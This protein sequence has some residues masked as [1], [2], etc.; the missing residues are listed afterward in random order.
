MDQYTSDEIASDYDALNDPRQVMQE[1][2]GL[3]S[4]L[5]QA[6]HRLGDA[7]AA[8]GLT[9]REW[10]SEYARLALLSDQLPD[11]TVDELITRLAEFSAA[12]GPDWLHGGSAEVARFTD[13]V[14]ILYG[15]L[16]PLRVIAQRQRMLSASERSVHPL[17]RTLGSARVG[18]PLDLVAGALRDL[19]ALSP[20]LVPLTAEEWTEAAPASPHPE[21]RAEPHPENSEYSGAANTSFDQSLLSGPPAAPAQPFTRLRDFAPTPVTSTQHGSRGDPGTWLRTRVM[22]LPMYK[23]IVVAAAIVIL[24]VGTLVLSRVGQVESGVANKSTG[25]SQLVASPVSVSLACTG[26]GATLQVSLRNIGSTQVEWSIQAPSGL[27]FSATHGTLAPGKTTTLQV[28]ASG[29]KAEQGTI[30]FTSSGGLTRVPYSVSCRQ[31]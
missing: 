31:S 4:D 21:P 13:E 8:A 1:V 7:I 23:W 25:A 5:R 15:V 14:E 2:V 10:R 16:R 19:E 6:A 29:A 20:Y 27:R 12:H 17:E 18:T 11:I 26:S 3:V 22:R 30:V 28:R 24:G 9:A